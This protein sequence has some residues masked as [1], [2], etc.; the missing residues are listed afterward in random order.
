MCQLR[1]YDCSIPMHSSALGRFWDEAM[2]QRANELETEVM[3]LQRCLQLAQSQAWQGTRHV[4]WD[5]CVV[6]WA[7][8]KLVGKRIDGL[9]C[10]WYFLI[11][12]LSWVPALPVVREKRCKPGKSDLGRKVGTI[13]CGKD[14][15]DRSRSSGEWRKPKRE[16][17]CTRERLG[18]CPAACVSDM[19]G[20][21]WNHKLQRQFFKWPSDV[22]K[23]HL[24]SL[25]S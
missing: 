10:C 1:S 24:F 6:C 8:G 22:W 12:S 20:I 4:V 5:G 13:R 25:R 17:P 21:I 18:E 3:D 23:Y 15:F 19:F 7:S 9:L 2:E 11:F 14:A 16:P